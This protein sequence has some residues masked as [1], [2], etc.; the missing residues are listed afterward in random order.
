MEESCCSTTDYITTLIFIHFGIGIL[1]K[2]YLCKKLD[3]ILY[4]VWCWGNHCPFNRCN[5]FF[6]MDL[7]S[8]TLCSYAIELFYD[9]DVNVFWI[10]SPTMV[11]VSVGLNPVLSCITLHTSWKNPAISWSDLSGVE[12]RSFQRFSSPFLLFSLVY[13]Q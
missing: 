11:Q 12:G 1:G 4:N 10:G 7:S 13:I 3:Y 9:W 5:L 2:Y 8:E 6:H